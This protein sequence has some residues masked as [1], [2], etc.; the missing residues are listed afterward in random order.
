[1]PIPQPGDVLSYAYLWSHEAD[2]G[3]EEGLKDRPVA[4]VVA[5]LTGRG[6]TELI[7]LPVTH[8][9]PDEAADGMEMPKAIKRNLGLDSA[10]SWIMLSEVNRFVWPGPDIRPATK[11]G[12]PTY[13]ALPDWFFLKLRDQVAERLGRGK[14]RDLKRSQ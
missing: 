9:Q 8:R 2:R 12:A 3:Q 4:V 5:R 6:L 13:G 14:L 1:M 7:V 11:E 10:R